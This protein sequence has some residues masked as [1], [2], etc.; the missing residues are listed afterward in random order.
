MIAPRTVEDSLR[1]EY[2]DLVPDMQRT[3]VA[4]D[5]E[6]RHRLV[7][8]IIALN[9]YEQIRIVSRLKEC[10]SAVDAL[11][12]RQELRRFDEDNPQSYSLTGLRD[13]VGIRVMVFP[14]NRIADV[15]SALLPLLSAW[16]SD[17]IPGIEPEDPPIALK[18]H[19]RC[20]AA[21]T[22]LTAELQIVSSLIG[23]FWEV[24]HSAVYK[25]SPSMQG[26]MGS[27]RMNERQ[28]TVLAALRDF[29]DEFEHL[30]SE[31]DE[32]GA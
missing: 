6:V 24:E 7:P 11:R 27:S 25:T 14:R 22:S 29:E 15:H 31:A 19:G 2:F 13:L 8:L 16:I 26:L 3:L 10:G 32:F 23:S 20:D 30:V 1:A 28:R 4:L 18:Y 12:R 21:L 9:R 17:P 5:S